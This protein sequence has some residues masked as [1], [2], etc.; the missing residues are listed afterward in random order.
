[1]S[2][3][4]G[5][6]AATVAI[7]TLFGLAGPR[8]SRQLRPAAAVWLLSVGSMLVAAS[9]VIV[10]ALVVATV[11][12]QWP[13][14]ARFGQWSAGPLASSVSADGV[15]AIA[16]TVIVLGQSWR[17]GRV[18]WVRGRPLVSAWLACRGA[19]SELVVI[20]DGPPVAV[21]VPGWPGRVVV[22]RGLLRQMP[23]EQWRAV[24]AHERGHLRARHDLHLLAGALAAAA[25]PLLG[26]V[27]AAL[28]LATERA[29]DEL[30]AA[31][32]GDRRAVAQ[33]IGSAAILCSAEAHPAWAMQAMGAD[34]SLRVRHLLD[35][36]PRHRPLGQAALVA[37]AAAAVAVAAFGLSDTKH[38][39]EFAE[40]AQQLVSL[41]R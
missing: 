39:F 29:A 36:P 24:L 30:S 10:P 25:D 9:T 11:V 14:L 38:L 34:V 20:P 21:A 13:P 31:V 1:M 35:G 28:R 7:S 40:R 19:C 37:L 17:L 15:V 4:H 12:G 26:R 3:P 32:T 22:S 27:P 6:L 5:W 18:L 33:A 41:H 2:G 16:A 23:S 8:L